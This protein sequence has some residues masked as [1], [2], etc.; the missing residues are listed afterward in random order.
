MSWLQAL[1]QLDVVCPRA[2]ASMH[3]AEWQCASVRTRAVL[4]S[5]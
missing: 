1:T 2:L 4:M 3:E 5:Q